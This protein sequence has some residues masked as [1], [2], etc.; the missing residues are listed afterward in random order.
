MRGA[1]L[2]GVGAIALWAFL[3]VLARAA[4]AMPPLQLTAM[5]FA[6]A[7]VLGLL[8]L[9][10]LIVY[11]GIT[12]LVNPPKVAGSAVLIVAVVGI[13]VNLAATYAL[14]K[15]NRQSMNVEGAFQHILTDLAAFIFTA[16]AGA[17]I[18]I[19]GFR[20]ADGIAS[21]VVAA[22]M[23]HASYGL[24]KASGRVFLEAAP[25]NL[26]PDQIGQ[27]M[28][29]IDGVTEIHDL[30]V[31]E[32]TSGFPALSAHVLVREGS[33]CH[34]L[35]RDLKQLGDGHSD[36]DKATL[37]DDE[38]LTAWRGSLETGVEAEDRR[39][40]LRAAPAEDAAP[41]IDPEVALFY[42]DSPRR[43]KL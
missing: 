41:P 37:R 36:I 38:E 13:V 11:E 39:A 14:S 10:L 17:I 22:I 19:T 5:S 20:R 40:Q 29:Q 42:R 21:L 33:D 8:V 32:V 18:L 28:T 24:L 6:V 4:G 34:Q 26:D 43:T 31:W 25:E 2:A 1:T 15:A 35:G 30:H 27:H 12:R 16:I 23:L 7:A 3:G 9:A